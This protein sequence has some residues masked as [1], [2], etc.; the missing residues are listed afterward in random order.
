[1]LTS[2]DFDLARRD[3]ALPGLA[4]LLDPE[5]F[6]EAI[7][8][9][10]PAAGSARPLYVRYKP[11]TNAL[12]AFDLDVAGETVSVHAKAHRPADQVKFDK[13]AMRP[14][15]P[16]P[17]GAGRLVLA[18][19]GIVVSVFP[20]DAKL[21]SLERLADPERRR[22]LLARLFPGRPDLWDGNLECLR[23]KPERRYVACLRAGEARVAALKFFT[24][25]G[26]ASA[27]KRAKTFTPSGPFRP[28]RVAASSSRHRILAF[29]WLPGRVLS[30]ALATGAAARGTLEHVGAALAHLHAVPGADLPMFTRREEAHVLRAVAESVAFLLPRSARRVRRLA[31]RLIEALGR[32]PFECRALHGDFYAKQILVDG[33]ET[34]FLDFDRSVRGD[35]ATDP[36]TFL[37]HLERNR[38]RG[39]L[40]ED[41]VEGA[42]EALLEGYRREAPG[43]DERRVR[44][45]TAAGL[46]Q[47][48]PHPFRFREPDWPARTEALL[49]RVEAL[50]SPTAAVRVHVPARPAPED[51]A[52]PFL[53]EALDP[54]VVRRRFRRFLPRLGFTN[55]RLHVDGA[56][57]VRHRPGRRCLIEYTLRIERPDGFTPLVLLG[58]VRAKGLDKT[59]YWVTR[60]LWHDGFNETAADGIH[61]PEPIGCAPEFRMWLQRKAPG[62][63]ATTLLADPNARALAPRIAEALYKLHTSDYAP[64]RRHTL[65]DELRILHE[66]LPL[67]AERRPAWRPRLERLLEACDRLGASLPKTPPRPIHRDCHPDNL[68]VDGPRLYFL[69]LDLACVGDPALD[70]GN[71]LAHVTEHSLRTTGD[72]STLVAWETAF[73]DAFAALHGEEIRAAV[74]AYATLSLVRHVHI[75]TRIPERRCI[76]EALIAL[77][78]A[79]LAPHFPA[80]L[81][82]STGLS[83][84]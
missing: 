30:E 57:M 69:D 9:I 18:P 81:P 74:R 70:A 46:F 7:R 55:A 58:K 4:T 54:D 43:L 10:A 38:L 45:Y 22:R 2:H 20:N 25:T 71:L 79:R 51:P 48:T 66:R 67:V 32:T 34:V 6:S 62:V 77:C 35:P 49:S 8:R 68:L 16:G 29:E 60:T 47:L 19:E 39:E 15:V 24:G 21:K 65:A 78:E 82:F 59:T 28:V 27:H 72:P 26:F 33:N 12:F 63:T 52:M 84:R 53:A 23:Y 40:S 3:T 61:I 37:A 5:A 56:R 1:M 17:L 11:G 13:A 14:A 64:P 42:C 31:E 73:E 50:L 44:P 36:G 83:L 76:T 80:T 75:S 41:A